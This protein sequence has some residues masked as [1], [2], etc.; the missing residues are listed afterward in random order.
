MSLR[1]S[2]RYTR[3]QSSLAGRPFLSFFSALSLIFLLIVAGNVLANLNKKEVKR[4]IVTKAVAVYKIGEHPSVTLQARIEKKGVVQIVAQTAGVVQKVHKTEGETVGKGTLLFSLSSNY[5]G[6][7]AASVQRQIAATQYKNVKDTFDTQKELIAKQREVADKTAEN[8]DDMRDIARRSLDDTR[9][10]LGQNETILNS[11]NANLENLQNTNV[12]GANDAIILQTQQ[13]VSQSQ[14]GVNQLRASIRQLE[15]QADTDDPAVQLQGL[16]KDIA[17]KQ[18]EVQ[19][20]ALTLNKEISRLQ[21]H[22]ASIGESLMFPV[23]PV[24]GTVERVFV[25]AGDTVTPGTPLAVISGTDN[26]IS[27]TVQVPRTL[28]LTASRA[29]PSTLHLGS[30]T[31]KIVPYYVSANAT[32]GSLHTMFYAIEP[33]Y[34]EK[35]AN[36]EYIS[37]DVPVG[38]L[39]QETTTPYVPIDSVYQSQTEAYVY[40]VEGKKAAAR[41]IILGDVYG[42]YVAVTQG[43]KPADQVITTRTVVAGDTVTVR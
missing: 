17:L 15:L 2:R 18:L 42:S 6:G 5:N 33:L 25:S 13:L 37:I 41:K 7:N 14:A 34:A 32:E 10:L 23:S 30:E 19:E 27:A 29:D 20:K 43:L 31:I 35:V 8:T 3:F 22:F 28:A 21:V 9:G 40:V 12:A 11:L 38:L 16:Q 26:T 39:Q 36:N 4:P 1:H 24:A